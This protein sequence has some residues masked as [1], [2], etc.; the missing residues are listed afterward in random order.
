MGLGVA[1][2]VPRCWIYYLSDVDITRNKE[3]VMDELEV[4]E[5]LRELDELHIE[6][7]IA[8]RLA[9]IEDATL[10]IRAAYNEL[11]SRNNPVTV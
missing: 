6:L 8:V 7:F 2:R 10:Q 3:V 9:R 1:N 4:R 11:H 5:H